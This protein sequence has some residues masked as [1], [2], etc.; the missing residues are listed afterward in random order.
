MGTDTFLQGYARAADAGELDTI[1]FVIAGAERVKDD[2]RAMW[3]PTGAA[4]AEGYGCTECA[5]VLACNVPGK[6]ERNGTVGQLVPGVEHRLEPVEGIET[7]GRL[8]VRGPNIMLGYLM[9]D[10]PG[11]IVPPRTAGTTPATSSTSRTAS[12]ASRAAPSASPSSAAR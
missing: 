8:M 11:E 6:A 4:I 3:A 9:A 7:G 1:K 2:T 5:P 10:R 12:C